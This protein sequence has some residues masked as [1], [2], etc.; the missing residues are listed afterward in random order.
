V[1]A[2]FSPGARQ[3]A[4][5]I[6]AYEYGATAGT[7][8][9]SGSGD[10]PSSC[11]EGLTLCAEV[12]VDTSADPANCGGCGVAC[13]A[14]QV[15]SAGACASACAQGLTQCGHGCVDTATD[16]LNCGS[17]GI[18]CQLGQR[19]E[20]GQCVGTPTGGDPSVPA[21]TGPTSIPANGGCACSA[22]GAG[23]TRLAAVL[24][25]M[26]GLLALGRRRRICT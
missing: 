5:D 25:T 26:L 23:R 17:C 14:D 6:G 4:P 21:A 16:I 22:V 7:G 10:A 13:P 12:C 15:C 11:S 1:A 19:C 20:Q 2:C 3:G 9:S 18:S 8:D 24:G